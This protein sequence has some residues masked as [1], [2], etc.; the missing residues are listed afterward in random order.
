MEC[1]ERDRLLIVYNDAVAEMFRAANNL[2]ER[3]GRSSLDDYGVLLRERN[4]ARVR[5]NYARSVYDSHITRHVC[6]EINAN[7]SRGYPGV[8]AL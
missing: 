7:A 4:R 5:A 1:E 8:R 6:S 3:A 2:S